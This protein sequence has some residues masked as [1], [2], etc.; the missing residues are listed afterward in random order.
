MTYSFSG[1][2][3][4]GL[5]PSIGGAILIGGLYS[6]IAQTSLEPI[7][8]LFARAVLDFFTYDWIKNMNPEM[9]PRTQAKIYAV[10]NVT[11]NLGILI[12]FRQAQLIG[13]IGGAFFL[14]LM[15]LELYCKCLNFSK[16]R[17][18]QIH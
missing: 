17:V 7:N 8:L 6:S 4:S 5:V 12:I 13:A 18:E 15:G 16:Y 11:V 10:T 9:G 2:T 1:P 14:S 3:L